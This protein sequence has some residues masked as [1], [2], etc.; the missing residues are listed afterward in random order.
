M[1]SRRARTR[2]NMA[3][4]AQHGGRRRKMAKQLA[5]E[6]ELHEIVAVVARLGAAVSR[7]AIGEALPRIPERTLVRRLRTLVDRG[8]LLEQGPKSKRRYTIATAAAPS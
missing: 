7:R 4:V 8:T 3:D 5:P 6:P 1:G 2:R